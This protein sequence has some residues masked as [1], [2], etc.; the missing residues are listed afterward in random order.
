MKQRNAAYPLPSQPRSAAERIGRF[1]AQAVVVMISLFVLAVIVVAVV[2]GIGRLFGGIF[3]GSL[4]VNHTLWLIVGCLVVIA[5]TGA[6]SAR[7]GPK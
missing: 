2:I 1:L 5:A 4:F 6:L 7:L 3:D